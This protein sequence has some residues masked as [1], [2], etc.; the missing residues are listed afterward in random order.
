MTKSVSEPIKILC[1][2]CEE[3]VL[4]GVDNNMRIYYGRILSHDSKTLLRNNWIGYRK[5]KKL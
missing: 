4:N 3:K 5:A 1:F 2:L